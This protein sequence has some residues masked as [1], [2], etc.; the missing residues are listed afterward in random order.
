MS[1]KKGRETKTNENPCQIDYS[2]NII[3]EFLSQTTNCI[4]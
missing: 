4:C 3:D 1:Q 2:H